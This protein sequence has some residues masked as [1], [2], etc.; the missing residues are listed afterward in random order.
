MRAYRFGNLSS[1]ICRVPTP[2][3]P[4]GRAP[5]CRSALAE[6]AASRERSIGRRDSPIQRELH[7]ASP[8][9][10]EPVLV[11]GP[12]YMTKRLASWRRATDW[13]LMVIAVGSLPLLL[14]EL[15][16]DVLP[17]G[18]EMFLRVTNLLVLAAFLVD[19]LVELALARNRSVYVRKEWMSP[20]IVI[21]QA[22]AVIPSLAGFGVLRVF[23]GA[24]V[25]RLAAL[26]L[27][28]AAI[29]GAAALDGRRLIREHAA[30]VAMGIAGLTWLTSAAT[31]TIAEDVGVNG[32]VH[33]FG[34]ALW[35]SA[36]TITTV[37]YGDVYPVTFAGRVT[38]VF[39]MVVGVST[40]ALVTA[41]LAQF[42][43]RDGPLGR[44]NEASGSSGA[45]DGEPAAT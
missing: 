18:D 25:F 23:R 43:V 37:G 32:R 8:V 20:L 31:F 27:R 4:N 30:A 26:V 12:V 29:G 19:Y 42:L 10:G 1:S 40:F 3:A 14:L 36:S 34:D 9:V 17:S 22:F 39:T 11:D 45:G 2:G 7:L 24:R 38:G 16:R 35:W 44:D 33:S 15:K 13:P 41:K 5:N 6:V 21:S 28:A